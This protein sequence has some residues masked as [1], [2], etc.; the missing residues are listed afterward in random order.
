MT[1]NLRAVA[2]ARLENPEATLAELG[3]MIS[4]ALGKSGVNHRLRR[5]SEIANRL[6]ESRREEDD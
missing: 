6:R 4:P 3:E 5:L 2:E 1:A